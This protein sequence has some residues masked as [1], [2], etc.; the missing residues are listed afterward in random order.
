MTNILVSN[1]RLPKADLFWTLL[2]IWPA[3]LPK[4]PNSANLKL[5]LWCFHSPFLPFPP[6][7]PHSSLGFCSKTPLF[8]ILSR[9]PD[10][11]VKGV[12]G[13]DY[14][15]PLHIKQNLLRDVNTVEV[16]E[17]AYFLYPLALG[18]PFGWIPLRRLTVSSQ[19]LGQ[20]FGPRV[21]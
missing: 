20:P 4:Q 13:G 5:F 10:P 11:R 1:S 16:L 6:F 3:T 19:D 21:R 12:C 9:D 7:P 15:Y 17:V 18:D 2:S 14:P 8:S